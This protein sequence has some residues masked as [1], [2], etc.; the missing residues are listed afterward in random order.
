VMG[1]LAADGPHA[2]LSESLSTDTSVH[3]ERD[4]ATQM[5]GFDH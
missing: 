4:C 3:Q 1:E 5:I 2:V